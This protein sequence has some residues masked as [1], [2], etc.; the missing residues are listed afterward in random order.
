MP[1]DA[2]PSKP[3]NMT[4]W[5]LHPRKHPSCVPVEQVKPFKR[6]G[7]GRFRAAGGKLT[8]MSAVRCVQVAGAPHTFA[9]T[10]PQ[11][12]EALRVPAWVAVVFGAFTGSRAGRRHAA[13]VEAL[14]EVKLWAPDEQAALVATWR[15]GGHD[16]VRAFIERVMTARLIRERTTSGHDT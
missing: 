6:T 13:V 4:D 10:D 2:K 14:S 7:W 8:R 16:A 1:R 3:M 5:R 12:A 11:Q 9:D 15:I